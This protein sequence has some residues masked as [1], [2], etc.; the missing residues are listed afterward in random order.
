M[1]HTG[2][3]LALAALL[4]C[5]SLRAAE[6]SA[7]DVDFFETRIRPVLADKCFQCHSDRAQKL[8]G[9]LRLDSRALTLKGGDNGAALIPGDPDHSPIIRA[10][11]WRDPDFQMP[12]KE[13]LPDEV[14]ADFERWV[15]SGAP[16]PD[17]PAVAAKDSTAWWDRVAA[18]DLP[19]ASLP[20]EKVVDQ[21]ITAKLKKSRV[22][23][24]PLGPDANLARR[25]TLDLAGRIPT[26]AEAQEFAASKAKDKRA[27][28]ADRLM[29]SPGFARHMVHELDWLLMA[30]ERTDLRSYLTPAVEDARPWDR[31]FR[32]LVTARDADAKGS[33]A[34]LRARV[35]DPD[36][37]VTEVSVRFFGVNISCA[38]C[39]DHPLV[40]SW[41]QDH[42]FGMKSFF[43]R[44]FDFGDFVAE[45]DYGAP[46]NFKTTKGESKDAKLM[47]LTGRVLD[48]PAPAEATAEQKKNEK[49]M[50][51]ELKKKKEPWPEPKFSRRAQLI[52]AGLRSG[53]EGFFSRA[54]VNRVWNQL[55][56]RGLVMPLDQMHGANAPSHPELLAWLARDFATHGYDLRRLVRGLVL[57]EAYARSSRWSDSQRPDASLFAVAVPRAMTPHQL[58]LALQCAAANPD[59]LRTG[60]DV[61]KQLKTLE[62]A[63][64]GW[65]GLFERTEENF[66]VSVDEALLVSNAEKMQRE[67]L[68]DSESRLLR[69]LATQDDTAK[70]VKKA[71][72]NVLSRP[73]E[74]AELK[75]VTAYLAKHGERPAEAWRHVLWSLMAGTEFRFNH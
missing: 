6:S 42:Y 69:G 14:I 40:P 43:S 20:I 11:R 37:M 73:P 39:H 44:T 49:Q 58:A 31:V 12:P 21:L 27:Q 24:A 32:E 56:G 47:F 67:L 33:S 30:G 25:L 55:F 50:M 54:I 62:G 41:K 59:G 64:Q 36:R 34:F 45:R 71:Y 72:W 60:E 66:Q 52:E 38:Q 51:E 74:P 16:F 18:K 23:P 61:S 10:V 53:D 9:G 19:P 28:L 46:V 15:R 70:A 22:K 26:A 3:R 2:I 17:K 4:A 57:S 5:T 65:A 48:E 35:K 13:K 8:K 68:G 7:R 63:A 1:S 75:T 29:A